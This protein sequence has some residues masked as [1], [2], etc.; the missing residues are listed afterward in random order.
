MTGAVIYGAVMKTTK[1][2][3]PIFVLLSVI[4]GN[5][6]PEG[7]PSR[8]RTLHTNLSLGIAYPQ[9]PLS[10]FR[11]PIGITGSAGMQWRLH[12]KWALHSAVNGLKTFSFGTVT[13]AKAT[14]KFDVIWISLNMQ[15]VVSNNFESVN[16]FAF[17]TGWYR[18]N[19]QLDRDIDENSTPGL[20]LGFVNNTVHR[21]HSSI[22]ELR[23]HLLFQPDDN[24]Q[25]L[26]ITYGILL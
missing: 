18:L 14:L 9:I 20:S 19:R 23:W 17:G 13:G 15:Y 26:T 22:L 6:Q 11:P 7:L 2:L 25:V 16:F 4:H 3:L 24:P 8:D 1:Y 5:A 21:K 10:Q 12:N